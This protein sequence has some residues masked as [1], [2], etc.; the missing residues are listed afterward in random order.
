MTVETELTRLVGEA[1]TDFRLT[2]GGLLVVKL[3]R[4]TLWVESAWR[5]DGPSG[6]MV[7]SLDVPAD[8]DDNAGPLM[9]SEV[10]VRFRRVVGQTVA[11]VRPNAPVIDLTVLFSGGYALST[12]SHSVDGGSWTLRCI[13]GQRLAMTTLTDYESAT[14]EDPDGQA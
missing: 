9:L 3:E 14:S 11:A 8:A 5:L 12:F 6:P 2:A 4:W 7:G 13:D 1:C 10:L